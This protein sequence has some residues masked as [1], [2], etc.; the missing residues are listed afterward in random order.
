MWRTPSG[1]DEFEHVE[2]EAPEWSIGSD[3]HVRPGTTRWAE[4]ADVASAG[5][6]DLRWRELP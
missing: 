2:P 3:T 4:L 5:W 1:I 6:G